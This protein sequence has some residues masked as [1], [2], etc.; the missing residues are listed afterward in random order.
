MACPTPPPL[1]SA[2][3]DALP[4]R[5][6]TVSL[7]D[8]T[9]VPTTGT[10]GPTFT[11]RSPQAL[12]HVAARAWPAR[13]RPRLRHR[14]ARR[15]RP[16]RRGQLCSTTGSRPRSTAAQGAAAG[17]RGAR[18]RPRAPAVAAA[19]ELTPRGRF[20]SRERDA[21]AVRHHYDVPTEFFRLFLG[22]S[23][24][25]SCA[26]FSRGATTLEE[27]QEAKHEL[28]C[29]KLGLKRGQRV[30]DVGSRLGR[31]RDPRRASATA[32]TSPASRSRPPQVE[33]ARWLAEEAGRRRPRRLPP[34]RLPRPGR[35]VLRRRRLDRD[36]RARRRRADGR[37]RAAPARR[38]APRR[39]A[40]P[41]RHREPAAGGPAPGPLLRA[42][43]LPRRR[44]AAALAHAARARAR[45]LRD[46]PHRGVPRRLRRDA[47]ALGARARRATSTRPSGSRAPSACACGGCTCGRPATA[48]RPASP[49]STRSAR[50]DRARPSSACTAARR[51]RASIAS[52]GR[53]GGAARTSARRSSSVPRPSR[54]RRWPAVR[55]GVPERLGL[56]ADHLAIACASHGGSDDHVLRVREMLRAA[57]RAEADLA[58]GPADPRDPRRRRRSIATPAAGPSRCATTA[59]ASTRFAIALACAE[60]WPVAGYFDAG[61]PVQEAM[62]RGL[63]E[64]TGLEPAE[65]PHAIDGCGMQTFS[66]PLAR[67]AD[68]F[69]RLAGGGLGPAGDRLAAAMTSHPELVAFDGALDT[70]L[71]RAHPGLVAKIGAE[72][73]L[74]IG[75][76]DGRGAALKVLD[77]AMRGLDPVALLRS[78]ATGSSARGRAVE[79]LQRGA[80][81]VGQADAEHALGADLGSRDRGA[82]ASA[83]CRSRRRRRRARGA[84]HRRGEALAGRARGRPRRAGRRRRRA[85]RAAPNVCCRSRPWRK[86]SSAGLDAQSP[87]RTPA[88]LT[89]CSGWPA[90]D[91]PRPA[92]PPRRRARARRRA[93]RSSCG[94]AA[95]G[96]R[97]P[98]AA[99]PTAVGSRGSAGPQA[100]V[101]LRAPGGVEDLAHPHTW[102]SPPP[103]DAHASARCSGPR[104]KRSGTPARTPASTWNGLAARRTNTAGPASSPPSPSVRPMPRGARSR[105]PSPRRTRTSGLD[106]SRRAD[107]VDRGEPV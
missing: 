51:S 61:H 30:L 36:G 2:L 43:R 78:S 5:P 92:S 3:A 75:L 16:R 96:A 64:A 62:W 65:L 97:P 17:R 80:A 35:R 91:S 10:D 68:A 15:R 70:E 52:R 24:T 99:Q 34:R 95:K 77:G 83:R 21:R 74:G 72:G 33:R 8:G 28:I 100:Q 22:P 11:A 59:R 67:L 49:R 55:A 102:P 6:F 66:V 45:G 20:H 107:L 12:A 26:I 56:G 40:A 14:R 4:E 41:A 69:G 84:C 76:P 60:G 1:R 19:A 29:Q 71:M 42:L 23:M 48:S 104:P 98:R 54:S 18:H 103:C 50:R 38:A 57:G 73:V 106:R 105:Q 32:C 47:A 79:H 94:A 46:A 90:S 85:A 37:V 88:L 89:C 58:C 31:V 87:P 27:A 86:A 81:A 93:C 101:G 9:E 63:A 53:V 44:A 82:R 7:W 25:Y 13:A 39:H